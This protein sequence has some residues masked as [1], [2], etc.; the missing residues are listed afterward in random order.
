M[1]KKFLKKTYPPN[2]YRITLNI[3]F[4]LIELLVVIAIIGILSAVLLP[5]YVAVRE[6]ARDGQRKSDLKKLQ[7]ALEL[8]RQ[9]NK[10]FPA[11]L[12][13]PGGGAWTSES[14][15][16]Y[17]NKIPF[18]PSNLTPTPY[19]YERGVDTLIYTLCTC[20]ENSADA[21]GQSGNCTAYN[22]GTGK[23]YE[24]NQP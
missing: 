17:L 4:T 9:D 22:C 23:K 24:L 20:L 10:D 19:S 15:L 13:T 5:N 11:A 12:P 3:G 21:D 16:T 8:Y 18:D 7:Q 14:G 1:K 2:T 6:R